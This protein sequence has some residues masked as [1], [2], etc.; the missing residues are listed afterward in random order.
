MRGCE[1]SKLW[2]G[3]CYESSVNA[4]S[5]EQKVVYRLNRDGLLRQFNDY[6]E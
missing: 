2:Q 1:A 6:T 4:S 3:D 5:R